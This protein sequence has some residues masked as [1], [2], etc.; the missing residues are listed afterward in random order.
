MDVKR[1]WHDATNLSALLATDLELHRA[2]RLDG[3][4]QMYSVDRGA[5]CR[6][7]RPRCWR[8]VSKEDADAAAPRE[9]V[10]EAYRFR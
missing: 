5:P 9:R 4:K 6:R 7:W 8:G 2:S 1:A 10:I 3:L